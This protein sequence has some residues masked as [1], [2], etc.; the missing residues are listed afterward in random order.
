MAWQD[1][2][3]AS[4]QAGFILA[5][6]PTLISHHKPPVSTSVMNAVLVSVIVFCLIT[7]ELWFAAITGAGIALVWIILAVQKSKLQKIAP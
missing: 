3:I 2:V 6:I 1:I 7:L 4:C 5:F